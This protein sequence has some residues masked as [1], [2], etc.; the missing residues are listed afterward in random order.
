MPSIEGEFASSAHGFLFPPPPVFGLIL[1]FQTQNA[2]AD[3]FPIRTGSFALCFSP[4]LFLVFA[5]GFVFVV[6]GG[7]ARAHL[8][9]PRPHF[10][11]G[12]DGAASGLPVGPG[13]GPPARLWLG[14]GWADGSL[15]RGEGGGLEGLVELSGF[16]GGQGVGYVGCLGALVGIDFVGVGLILLES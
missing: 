10:L 16:G 5:R 14:S 2:V 7:A 15:R 6:Q 12:D 8:L 4:S 13:A 11:P 9:G 1:P 3:A